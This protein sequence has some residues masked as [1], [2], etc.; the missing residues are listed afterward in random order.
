ML[1]CNAVLHDFANDDDFMLADIGSVQLMIANKNELKDIFLLKSGAQKLFELFS[2]R[3]GTT[4]APHP[5]YS[6]CNNTSKNRSR[7][8]PKTSTSL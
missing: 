7:S 1:F 4:D 5:Q 6:A 8:F 3:H 2:P